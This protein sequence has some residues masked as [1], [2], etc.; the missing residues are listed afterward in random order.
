M[1]VHRVFCQET[2]R[3]SEVGASAQRCAVRDSVDAVRYALHGEAMSSTDDFDYWA[4]LA[5]TLVA[6]SATYCSNADVLRDLKRA[7]DEVVASKRLPRLRQFCHDMLETYSE[8]YEPYE[9]KI[10][11]NAVIRE[12]LERVYAPKMKEQIAMIIERGKITTERQHRLAMSYVDR[13]I[14]GDGAENVER[15]NA[16]LRGYEDRL[17]ARMKRLKARGL[18]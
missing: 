12:H 7:L 13:A 8:G 2:R 9:Y 14:G 11:P 4:R 3:I 16:A 6:D 17:A 15:L 10:I 1:G 5:E 18:P